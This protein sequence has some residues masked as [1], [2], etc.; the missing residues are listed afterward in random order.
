MRKL[1]PSELTVMFDLAELGFDDTSEIK[2]TSY[3][4]IG[5]QRAEKAARF[6]LSLERPDYHLFVLGEAGSGRSSLMY[7]LMQQVAATRPAAS[8]LVY[9]Q[10]FECPER[11]LALRLHTG[12]AT[13]LRR[14]LEGFSERI[15]RDIP[16][17]LDE[18]SV[19]LDSE[20]LKKSH[21]QP[22]EQ[23]YVDLVAFAA[24]RHFALRREDGRLVFTLRDEHGQAMQEDALLAL[25]P[26]Q[27]LVMETAEQELRAEIGKYLE[28]VRPVEE[29]LEKA[30]MQLRREAIV[31]VIE[32]EIEGIRRAMAGKVLEPKKFARYLG[33]L[34]DDALRSMDLFAATP[35]DAREQI[36]SRLLRYRVNVLVD[37]SAN[38]G[39]PVLRDDDPV[40]RSLFG[41]I[42]FQAE[43]GVLATDFTRIRAGNLHRAHG[44]YLL[45]HLRDVVRDATVWEK[46][47]RYLRHGCLQIEE[48]AAVSGQ[49]S[50]MTLEPASLEIRTKLVLIGS[51]E[52]Y[53]GLQEHDPDLMRH[54]RVKVDF[55]EYFPANSET[56]RALAAFIAQRCRDL[57][58]PHFSNAAV[59]RLLLEMQR[60]ID[61]QRHIGTELGEL[62]AWL[63]EAAEFCRSMGNEATVSAQD[64]ADAFMARRERHDYPEQQ[65]LES[66]SAGELLIR[67][68]GAVVGQINGLAQVDLGDYRFG[69]PVRITARA[70]AGDEGVLNIDREVEMTCPSHDKGVFILQGWLSAAFAHLAPLSLS[71]SLVFEQEYHGVEGDSASCAELFALLSALSG[72]AL[73]QGLAVTGA[74][75]QHGEVMPVGG[76]NEKIEGWFRTCRKL[77]LDGTQ[78]AIVPARNLS[79]LVLDR[80]VLDA[81]ERGDFRIHVM[82]H[83][84]EGIAL[85][86]GMEAGIADESG[87]YPEDSVMGRAQHMLEEY[88]K[89]CDESG[90]PREHEHGK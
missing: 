4:W 77:G 63:I 32:R 37:N 40:F 76:I 19:R 74:M 13:T 39:A 5:Q 53:Y 9:L 34:A 22:A 25:S 88:R 12:Q 61:D 75:N 85:L 73:P 38:A 78:G 31:P 64:V 55:A 66:I 68:Q 72:I 26:E 6:G 27:R 28:T 15:A 10:N 56:R 21:R 58:L 24:A 49:L 52:D 62:E 51:R 57:G 3:G 41:G 23:A 14:V 90:H 20:R 44:G 86:T 1:A 71:A 45:L 80:E 84:L 18:E 69:L 81:V 67:V 54:F 48:P 42:D 29:A 59:A 47:Q 36:E 17:K 35:E 70:Y 89:A 83:V 16:H 46:L 50:A 60:G 87:N 7:R 11:P 33:E 43:S 8:D 30:L 65:M 2:E 82:N 79:H